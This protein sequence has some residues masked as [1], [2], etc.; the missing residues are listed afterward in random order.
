MGI[1]GSASYGRSPPEAYKHSGI[2][3]ADVVFALFD[4]RLGTPT[5]DA[6]SGTAEKIN[7]AVELGKPVHVYFSTAPLPRDIAVMFA[8][9]GHAW[10]DL[11]SSLGRSNSAKVTRL[12]RMT[13][14]ASFVLMCI[15]ARDYRELSE[16]HTPQQGG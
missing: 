3:D 16:D 8:Y 15:Q 5:P 9:Q 4:S 1:I 13:T 11:G 6:I 10:E 12:D 7:R 14:S 2:D